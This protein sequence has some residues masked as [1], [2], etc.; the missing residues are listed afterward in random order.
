MFGVAQKQ[1]AAEMLRH[2][3]R[4]FTENVLL[5]Y[6]TH[7]SKFGTGG[8]ITPQSNVKQKGWRRITTM[9]PLGH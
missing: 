6:L 7:G 5:V 2:S 1:R 4:P 9:G 8:K 3:T